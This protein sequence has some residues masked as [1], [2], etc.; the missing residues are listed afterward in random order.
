MQNI[1]NKQVKTH[2]VHSKLDRGRSPELWRKW[3]NSKE[4]GERAVRL[5]P[6]RLMGSSGGAAVRLAQ[7]GTGN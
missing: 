3:G 5:L 4:S 7:R 6:Q 1:N 2:K